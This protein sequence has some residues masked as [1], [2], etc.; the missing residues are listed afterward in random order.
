MDRLLQVVKTKL[1]TYG[2]IHHVSV[3]RG[4]SMPYGKY[5]IGIVAVDFKTQTC[6]LVI[7]LYGGDGSQSVL[8]KLRDSLWKG[9]RGWTYA[10]EFLAISTYQNSNIEMPDI[11]RDI[12]HRQ[13]S[14]Q[15]LYEEE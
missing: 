7:D 13:L 8:E 5:S 11:G 1:A 12:L 10:N 15:L 2:N 9:L 14:F 3:P 6:E 4:D